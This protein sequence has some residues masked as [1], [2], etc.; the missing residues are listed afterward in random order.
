M[1]VRNIGMKI[2]KIA[3]I[4]SFVGLKTIGTLIKS[5]LF[6]SKKE[7]PTFYS[8][9]LNLINIAYTLCFLDLRKAFDIMKTSYLLF[10]PINTEVNSLKQSIE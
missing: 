6:G 4:I 8:T 5:G 1:E 2:L 10:K 7:S 9:K 3:Y